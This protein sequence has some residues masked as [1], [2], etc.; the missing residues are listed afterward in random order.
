[1]TL[2]SLTRSCVVEV[3]MHLH[4]SWRANFMGFMGAA[5]AIFRTANQL[6]PSLAYMLLERLLGVF[7]SVFFD[8]T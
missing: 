7:Q 2:I 8:R 6:N 5:L 4:L 1:M 3:C